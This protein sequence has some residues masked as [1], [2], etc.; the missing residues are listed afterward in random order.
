MRRGASPNLTT[1]G[2]RVKT[3][4]AAIALTLFAAGCADVTTIDPEHEYVEKTYRT[5]SNIPTKS[6]PQADGVQTMSRDDYETWR[7]SSIRGLPCAAWPAPCP[8]SPTGH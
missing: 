7:N 8:T 6:N 4:L 5:G 1:K 3:Q 2:H